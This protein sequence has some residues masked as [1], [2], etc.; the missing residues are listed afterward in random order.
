[1][2][3][4]CLYMPKRSD[5]MQQ[6]FKYYSG[7][8][9]IVI[10][11]AVLPVNANSQSIL[12]K[13]ADLLCKPSLPTP[14]TGICDY[15][16]NAA[17]LLIQG[18]ILSPSGVLTNGDLL[19]ESDGRISCSACD[20]SPETSYV[21]ASKLV[22]PD[23]VISA[24]L[25]NSLEHTKWAGNTPEPQSLTRY[26]H[27]HQWRRGLDGLPEINAAP[28]PSSVIVAEL[29][30]ITNGV[31]SIISSDGILKLA[32]NLTRSEQLDG[33]NAMPV[34][35][36][37]FPLGDSSG[38]RLFSG[39]GYPNFDSQQAGRPFHMN[40][41]EGIDHYAINEFACL[42]DDGTLGG[43]NLLPNASLEHAIPLISDDVSKIVFNN[44]SIIWTPRSDISLYGTT[45]PVTFLKASNINVALGTYW[46]PTGSID[47]LSELACARDFNND[48]L[49]SRL[50]DKELFEMVTVNGAKSANMQTEI[51]QLLVGALADVTLFRGTGNDYSRVIN[52]QA[53]D[54][55]LVL[56]AGVPMY[57]DAGL[58][59]EMGAGGTDCDTVT[60]CGQSRR[61][62]VMRETGASLASYNITA[63]LAQCD[64]GSPPV[65]SCV[66]FRSISNSL[67]PPFYSGII[68]ASDLDGDG[69]ANQDDN[70]PSIF[71]PRIPG[72]NQPD[73]DLDGIG[74]ACDF[75]PLPIGSL[76]IDLF[77]SSFENTQVVGGTV[78]GIA[79]IGGSLNLTLNSV[80][81]ITVSTDGA[82]VFPGSLETGTEYQVLYED[83]SGSFDCVISNN[84]G[85]IANSDISNIIIT[86]QVAI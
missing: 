24:G 41:A 76:G 84:S 36:S 23:I 5:D 70:C 50:T 42:S 86:C 29:R 47:L 82:F 28:S 32:R 17:P 12:A 63:P 43:V 11:L 16:A 1:M 9:L 81:S 6:F 21:N 83:V 37:T 44:A 10:I 62:C 79:I 57:G 52:A 33:I 85:T 40:V 60:V 64:A 51:G 25:I 56:K 3:L 35:R 13:S 53:S 18:T 2:G 48:Y 46:A 77:Q 59:E 66:P 75:A 27:R 58:M 26:D 34:D 54:I 65:R 68:D 39:C 49:A 61:I 78:S 69:I 73:G 74:D 4:M 22:C 15:T 45:T 67:N 30:A 55:A 8:L 80:Q 72:P 14:A 7:L 38:F 31:T 71:N 20:C 19:I